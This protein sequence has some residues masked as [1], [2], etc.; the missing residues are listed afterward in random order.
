MISDPAR[1]GETLAAFALDA[2]PRLWREIAESAGLPED[3]R[4]HRNEWDCFGLYACVRG[5]VAAGGFNRETAAAVDAFHARVFE[6]WAAE[7]AGVDD[8]RRAMTAERYGEYGTIGQDGGAAGAA[9]V[10]LRLGKACALHLN[11]VP[12]PRASLAEDEL[13]ELT[14]EVHEALSEG[15]AE[16][17]RMAT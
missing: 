3:S 6:T 8:P 7:S 13:A 1:R 9:T 4:P 17:V 15:A 14:G 2:L 12:E 10:A 16:S 11:A 5:L